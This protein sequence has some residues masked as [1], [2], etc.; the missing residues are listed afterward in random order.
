MF[1]EGFLLIPRY[2]T[3]V[4]IVLFEL[5]IVAMDQS[6][7]DSVVSLRTTTSAPTSTASKTLSWSVQF[8]CSDV[9]PVLYLLASTLPH[10]GVQVMPVTMVDLE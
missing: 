2:Y 9:K 8:L 10:L 3:K 6:L 7:V 1:P 4:V 5:V